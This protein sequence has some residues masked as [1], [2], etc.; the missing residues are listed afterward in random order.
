MP[1]RI[2]ID[3]SVLKTKPASIDSYK[4]IE[5]L[6]ISGFIYCTEAATRVSFCDGLLFK[7]HDFKAPIKRISQHQA[8]K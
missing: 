6:S 7:S 5:I 2:C 3:K 1:N 8:Q 4:N